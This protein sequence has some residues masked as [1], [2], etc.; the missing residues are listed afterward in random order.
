MMRIIRAPWLLAGLIGSAVLLLGVVMVLAWRQGPGPLVAGLESED[1]RAATVDNFPA[2]FG[3]LDDLVPFAGGVSPVASAVVP[4]AHGPEFRDPDWVKAQ[5]PE[6]WTLQV[7]ASQ[8]ES[9]IKR[10]LAGLENRA[11]YVYFAYPQDGQTWYVVT[12]G[13]YSSRELALGVADSLKAPD[14]ARPFPRAMG[15]Y[16]EALSAAET[17]AMQQEVSVPDD[18]ADASA[19]A[20]EPAP[21]PS[22]QP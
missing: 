4:V 3:R 22:A 12:T 20:E 15:A 18:T 9:A 6:A 1:K 13:S 21:A 10:F 16:Q 19:E 14:G 11:D 2:D 7:L 8:D 17:A 5:G